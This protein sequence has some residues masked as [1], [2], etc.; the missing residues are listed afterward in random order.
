MVD[1]ALRSGESAATLRLRIAGCTLRLDIADA[2]LGALL[3]PALKQHVIEGRDTGTTPRCPDA[4]I[5]VWSSPLPRFPWNGSHL[6][7]GG[8]VAGL[9]HGPVRTVAATDGSSLVLWDS[10]RRVACCWFAGIRGVTRWDRAAPLRTALH[11]VLASPGRQ[12]VHLSLIH[13]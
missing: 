10:E 4:R 2:D 1:E 7:R 3:L 5:V 9:T 12:L 6:A 13:I 11:Y 8:A